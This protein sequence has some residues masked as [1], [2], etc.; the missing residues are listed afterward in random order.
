MKLK[1]LLLKKKVK[2]TF[3]NFFIIYLFYFICYYLI[4]LLFYNN[5]LELIKEIEINGEET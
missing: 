5:L 4:V 2:G 3:I 1:K